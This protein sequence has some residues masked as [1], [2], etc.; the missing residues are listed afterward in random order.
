M[1]DETRKQMSDI[2]PL[3]RDVAPAGFAYDDETR[4]RCFI[5]YATFAARN[6]AAVARLYASEVAGQDVP[7]PDTRTI[8]LWAAADDWSRQ[9]DDLWRN[10]KGR[11]SYELQILSQA[12]TMMGAKALHDILT[13]ADQRELNERIV[14]LKAIEVAM[15]AR[16]KLPELARI[17]PPEDRDLDDDKPRDQ[18]EAEALSGIARTKGTA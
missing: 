9:A 15:K 13:G 6:C 1:S 4:V 8:Q 14:T 5:L 16:E 7:V 18:R 12:N 10:T 11:T 3:R 2:V 17:E